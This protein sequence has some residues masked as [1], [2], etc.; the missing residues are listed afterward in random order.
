MSTRDPLGNRAGLS[1]TSKTD[2]IPYLYGI[3]GVLATLVVMAHCNW[4]VIAVYGGAVP[5]EYR[6]CTDF[7]RYLDFLVGPFFVMSGM[8]LMMPALRAPGFALPNGPWKFLRHRAER[9]LKPYYA[10]LAISFVLFLVWC[11]VV[12][13]FPSA[14]WLA[15]A[16]V[17]HVLIVHNFSPVTS[18]AINDAL[19]SIA[20]EFQCYIL[21]AFAMLPVLRRFGLAALLALAI[22]GS[23]LPHFLL[24]HF[25]DWSQPSSF[26][27]YAMGVGVAVLSSPTHPKLAAFGRRVR[28]ADVAVL[29]TLVTIAAAARIGID[30]GYSVDWEPGLPC[31]IAVSAFFL[32]GRVGGSGFTHRVAAGIRRALAWRPFVRLGGF[33]YSIYLVHF[34]V[35]RLLVGIAARFHPSPDV[36]GLLG[37]GIFV[38]LA[39]ASGFLFYLRF[40]RGT[41]RLPAAIAPEAGLGVREAAPASP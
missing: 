2:T 39:I 13:H 28:W 26:A 36:L 11:A 6:V 16:V 25:L 41:I 20:V 18:L 17:T 15:A 21:F 31:G 38:P 23:M 33:S 3:R 14:R 5:H 27:L 7:L 12:G 4:M 37:F 29:F 32:D 8:L 40:E 22:V 34:P 10:A 35:L 30:P 24:H 1:H 19:W 9:L